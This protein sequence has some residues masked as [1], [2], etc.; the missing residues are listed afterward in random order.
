[1]LDTW[2]SPLPQGQEIAAPG[3]W[4][5][6]PLAVGGLTALAALGGAWLNGWIQLERDRR[7]RRHEDEQQRLARLEEAYIS[8]ARAAAGTTV[9]VIVSGLDRA[10]P[11]ATREEK[12]AATNRAIEQLLVFESAYFAAY[13]RCE[14]EETRKALKDLNKAISRLPA[15]A[16]SLGGGST[17]VEMNHFRK[18]VR[19]LD[20]Q[21]EGLVERLLEVVRQKAQVRRA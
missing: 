17:T 15:L 5:W 2:L 19:E 13:V 6:M 7:A 16:N 9:V 10:E 21:I 20:S 1:M 14:D 8:V 11:T 12:Q 4:I 3:G 18:E